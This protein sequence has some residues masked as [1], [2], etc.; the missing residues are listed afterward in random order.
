MLEACKETRDYCSFY[1]IGWS[2]GHAVTVIFAGAAKGIDSATALRSPPTGICIP[3][4][5][6]ATQMGDVLIKYLQDHPKYRHLRIHLL[7]KTQHLIT[8]TQH[9]KKPSPAN[10]LAFKF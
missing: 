7:T 4:G 1:A 5:L 3:N 6:T 8:K 9:L 10:A 2:D